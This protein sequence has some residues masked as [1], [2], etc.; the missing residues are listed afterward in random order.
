MATRSSS[1]F[2]ID[3]RAI[4]FKISPIDDL[5]GVLGG[6]WDLE[7]RVAL[8]DAVK[9]RA[10]GQRYSDGAAWEETDLFRHSYAARFAAGDGVRGCF[11]MKALL[12]QYCTRVD[13]MFTDMKRRG[14]DAQA[15]PLPT[16]LIGRGGEVFIGNQGNHRLAMAQ[17]LGLSEIA[18]RIVCRHSSTP[19]GPSPR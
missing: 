13:E 8:E 14:F 10:I 9:H 4:R 17:V 5:H 19:A 12:N 1:E 2:W 11:T 18:G 3:P 6:N 15:G 7:R 16:F